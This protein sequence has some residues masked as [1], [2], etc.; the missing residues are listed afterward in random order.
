MKKIMRDYLRDIG[1]RGGEVTAR[2]GSS[3]FSEIGKRG[4]LKRWHK[5]YAN[6]RISDGTGSD[7]GKNG[8]KGGE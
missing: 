2:R 6:Q 3:H 1:R 7:S 8:G 4:A 5:N